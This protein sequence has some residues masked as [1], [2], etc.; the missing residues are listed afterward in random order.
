MSVQVFAEACLKATPEDLERL[1]EINKRILADEGNVDQTRED[2]RA[3][4]LAIAEIAG[5]PLIGLIVHSLL[6]LLDNLCPA[7]GRR[8][9][10]NMYKRHEAIIQAMESRDTA[11]CES[12]MTLETRVTKE[13][14]TP[15]GKVTENTNTREFLEKFKLYPTSG[16]KRK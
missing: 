5:N 2:H 3:F 14:N 9:L 12:L 7:T 11:L 6:L 15:A 13:L 4:H 1:R 8:G 16:R 10:T